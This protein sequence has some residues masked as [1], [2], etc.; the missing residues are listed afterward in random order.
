M[1]AMANELEALLAR[2][3]DPELKCQSCDG[4][5]RF[6]TSVPSVLWN[7]VIRKQGLP[8]YLCLSCIVREFVRAGTSF[9]AELYG[10]G[11]SGVPLEILINSEQAQASKLIQDENNALRWKLSEREST[12]VA[13]V[14]EDE[15]Q[16]DLDD[17]S[18]CVYAL[19]LHPTPAN[20]ALLAA[21]LAKHTDTKISDMPPPLASR[22]AAVP[23]EE[24][25]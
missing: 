3:R 17:L 12:P 21:W 2:E 7:A 25:T 1:R 11:F 14:R 23:S 16:P 6:D 5:H 20:W 22:G 4:L 8:E 9:T 19:S 24:Q 15:R 13:R 18:V 10:D